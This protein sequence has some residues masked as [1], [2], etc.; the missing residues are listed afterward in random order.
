[1]VTEPDIVSKGC[2]VVRDLQGVFGGIVV[3]PEEG[4]DFDGAPLPIPF[5][6]EGDSGPVSDL[7]GL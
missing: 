4:C 1:M 2:K 7:G 6:C 3:G 5:A